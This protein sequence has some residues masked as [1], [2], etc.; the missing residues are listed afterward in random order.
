MAEDIATDSLLE[1]SDAAPSEVEQFAAVAAPIWPAYIIAASIC[2]WLAWNTLPRLYLAG[3]LSVYAVFMVSRAF[4][5]RRYL[6][7]TPARRR[8]AEPVWRRRFTL[9]MCLYGTLQ[10]LLIATSI[11]WLPQGSNFLMTWL[12]FFSIVL[13][14]TVMPL[15]VTSLCLYIT[16]TLLPTAIAWL[17]VD[18]DY[19]WLISLGLVA[20]SAVFLKG[21]RARLESIRQTYR[22]ATQLA[23][24]NALLRRSNVSRTRM[25]MEASHDLRQPAHALGMMVERLRH[26]AP[27]KDADARI[28]EIEGGIFSLSDMLNELMEFSRLDVGEYVSRAEPVDLAALLREVDQRLGVTAQDKGLAWSVQTRP[29]W[30]HSD[31]SLLRRIINNLVTNAVKYTQQGGVAVG[32]VPDGADVRVFVRDTGPG[33][34][35]RHHARVFVEYVRL[36]NDTNEEPGMGIGLAFARRAAQALGHGLHLESAPGEGTQVSVTMRLCPSPAAAAGATASLPDADSGSDTGGE[37][38]S[39]LSGRRML[40]LENDPML[41]K[42]MAAV[43]TGW[44]VQV[45]ALSSGEEL[46]QALQAPGMPVPDIILADLH[47]DGDITGLQAVAR[48][49]ARFGNAPIAAILLTGDLSPG[50]EEQARAL[51]V[52]VAYKPLRPSRLKSLV[53]DEIAAADAAS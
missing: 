40:L 30:V 10:S 42:S 19:N 7:L 13:V 27:G 22:L 35:P 4:V 34:D 20:A 3:W 44:G 5:F 21:G 25:I 52:L 23:E 29:V 8:D 51:S 12:I 41:R 37:L 15:S 47:L 36:H 2:V 33:I 31:A 18:M 26:T 9:V 50:V 24:S 16:L 38:A 11:P 6:G 28:R 45:Q 46:D 48:V 14:T 1:E 49:R 39:G 32:C 53:I 43:V 17:F